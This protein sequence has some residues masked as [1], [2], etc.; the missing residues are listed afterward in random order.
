MLR[1]HR[2]STHAGVI[3]VAQEPKKPN[4]MAAFMQPLNGKL[5]SP[6]EVM[7]IIRRGKIS[8]IT[9]KDLDPFFSNFKPGTSVVDEESNTDFIKGMIEE[10]A[11]KTGM[12]AAKFVETVNG[13]TKANPDAMNLFVVS[14]TKAA[15]PKR[16]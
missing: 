1:S 7:R 8:G 11:E 14:A 3:T 10:F 9:D 4:L 2:G 16:N 13:M 5:S 6:D 15:A 12:T